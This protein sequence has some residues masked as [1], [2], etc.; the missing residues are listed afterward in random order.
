MSIPQ[1]ASNMPLCEQAHTIILYNNCTF[2]KYVRWTQFKITDISLYTRIGKSLMKKRMWE[3]SLTISTWKQ[4]VFSTITGKIDVWSYFNQSLWIFKSSYTEKNLYEKYCFIFYFK[5][6]K[7]Y[8]KT[9]TGEE[10]YTH[11]KWDKN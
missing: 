5:F 11:N 10:S 2:K 1:S 8:S 4:L 7:N 9:N 3:C 6:S